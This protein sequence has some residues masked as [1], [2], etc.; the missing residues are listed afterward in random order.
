MLLNVQFQGEK[1]LL[2]PFKFESNTAVDDVDDSSVLKM[3]Y[4]RHGDHRKV[5][6]LFQLYTAVI[7]SVLLVLSKH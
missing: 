2:N 3:P 7:P 6:I 5:K 4:K 1:I